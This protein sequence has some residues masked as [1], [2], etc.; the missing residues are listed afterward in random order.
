MPNP[1]PDE[2]EEPV[3]DLPRPNRKHG[4]M[5]QASRG[6]ENPAAPFEGSIQ[7]QR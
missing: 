6:E 2:N 3:G 7:P 1:G 4:K 5:G